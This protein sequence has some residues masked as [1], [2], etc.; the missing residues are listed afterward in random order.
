MK[1]ENTLA[2]K[3]LSD[4][5]KN[6]IEVVNENLALKRELEASRSIAHP[7]KPAAPPLKLKCTSCNGTGKISMPYTHPTNP[8]LDSW[9]TEW[10]GVCDGKGNPHNRSPWFGLPLC[11]HGYQNCSVC[12]GIQ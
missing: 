12:N 5:N 9:R 2:R 11:V 7:S 1:K 8:N 10:C 4:T 6:Y 3:A